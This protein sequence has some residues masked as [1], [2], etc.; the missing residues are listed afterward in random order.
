MPQVL[1]KSEP[2]VADD[3][4]NGTD[5]SETIFANFGA[6]MKGE[7]GP[8]LP[9]YADLPISMNPPDEAPRAVSTL[10]PVTMDSHSTT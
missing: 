4:A 10:S 8:L 2:S 5:Y 6:V 7:P 9:D 3:G 1:T